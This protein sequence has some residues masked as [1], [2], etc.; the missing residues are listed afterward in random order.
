MSQLSHPNIVRLI[1]ANL[2]GPR[3]CIVQEL[4]ATDLD[5]V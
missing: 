1:G 3:I 5:K 2:S 4:M